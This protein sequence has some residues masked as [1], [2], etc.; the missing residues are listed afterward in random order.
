[1]GNIE[2]PALDTVD[3]KLVTCIWRTDGQR[4]AS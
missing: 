2:A 1:M 3:E 4:L